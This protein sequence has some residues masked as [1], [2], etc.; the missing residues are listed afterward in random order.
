MLSHQY[1]LL[2]NNIYLCGFGYLRQK[3]EVT[4]SQLKSI[5]FVL[6]KYFILTKNIS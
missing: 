2:K 5:V 3:A 6:W 4:F 1:K